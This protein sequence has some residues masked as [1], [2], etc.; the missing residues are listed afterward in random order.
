MNLQPDASSPGHYVNQDWTPGT[1]GTFAVIIG[2]SRYAHLDGSVQSYGLGQLYVSALTA[3][4]FFT[5]LRDEYSM[6]SCPLAECWLLLAP[7]DAE[8]QFEPALNQHPALPTMQQCEEAIGYWNQAMQRLS[9]PEAATS[10]AVFFFSGHGLEIH[11]DKQILLP[12]DYLRPPAQNVNDALSTSFLM[13]GLGALD[14]PNQ[15]FFLDACRNDAQ[16]LREQDVEG[17]RVLNIATSAFTNSNRVAPLFYATASGTQAW[18]PQD[19]SQGISLFGQA[20][21]EGLSGDPPLVPDCNGA[22]CFV[23]VFPLQ[24]YLKQRVVQLLAQYGSTVTQPVRLGGSI[25][26]VAITEVPVPKGGTGGP[27]G[28]SPDLAATLEAR[29][30][31]RSTQPW[32]YTLGAAHELFGSENV[33]A[34][35]LENARVFALSQRAWLPPDGAFK[36]HR[37]DR[38]E[39][40]RTFR[41]ALSLPKDPVGHLFQLSDARNQ[42]VCILP[43]DTHHNPQFLLELDVEYDDDKHSSRWISRLEASL[44]RNNESSELNYVADLWEQYGTQTIAEA[45]AGMEARFRDLSRMRGMPDTG[46]LFNAVASMILLRAGRE[47]LL[48]DWVLRALALPAAQPDGLVLLAETLLR[49]RGSAA[50]DAFQEP[51]QLLL[52]LEQRGLPHLAEVMGYAARQVEDLLE[53]G[54]ASVDQQARLKALQDRLR[55]ALRYFRNDGLFCVFS[56]ERDTFGPELILP[57]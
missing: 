32:A 34:L 41:I 39:G 23:N 8:S 9:K 13:K 5:W 57:G 15:F 35:W 21:V 28:T 51:I 55:M 53:F 37:V 27:G 33:S 17:R 43:G 24:K 46:W 16:K 49:R 38:D 1:A 42:W 6:A 19:P 52:G 20:L 12:S 25:D 30:T 50:G 47:D 36:I 18:Q 14:V 45:V 31:H 56:G 7:A 44:S 29:Y 3:Y 22:H 4:Q 10:R 54:R 48:H 11:Q 2:V 40:R 26:D